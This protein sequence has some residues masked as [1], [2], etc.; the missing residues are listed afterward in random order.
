LNRVECE[1]PEEQDRIDEDR[2]G[3]EDR[4]GGQE[5]RVGDGLIWMKDRGGIERSKEDGLAYAEETREE[6]E[7][8]HGTSS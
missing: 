4:G 1:Q 2:W 8:E 6:I 7:N 3:K 5:C